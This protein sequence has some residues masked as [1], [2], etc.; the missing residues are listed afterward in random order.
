MPEIDENGKIEARLV[1]GGSS[2]SALN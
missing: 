1:C 2:G